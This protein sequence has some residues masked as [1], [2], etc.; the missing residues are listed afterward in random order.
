MLAPPSGLRF[1]SGPRSRALTPYTTT[2]QPSSVAAASSAPSAAPVDPAD[3]PSPLT[4]KVRTELVL[5][6]PFQS[7]SSFTFPQQKAGRRCQHE[8][9]SRLLVNGEKVRRSWLTCSVKDDG[10]HCFCCKTFSKRDYKL[11]REGRKDREKC[12]SLAQSPRG[13]P[14]A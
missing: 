6:G 7:E 13:E 5:R 10:L 1:L 4:D 8:Y 14:G 3:W 12:K 11:N 9:F 2:A